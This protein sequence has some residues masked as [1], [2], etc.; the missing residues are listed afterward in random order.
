M[1]STKHCC[2]ICKK[3]FD[4][5]AGLYKHRRGKHPETLRVYANFTCCWDRFHCSATFRYV[6]EYI[7]HLQVKHP[8][9]NVLVEELR[10]DCESDFISWKE[11]IE[12]ETKS[13][14]VRN[15]GKRLLADGQA[16]LSFFCNRLGTF[17]S[18]KRSS[19]GDRK[20]SKKG[21]KFGSSKSTKSC[22]ASMYL[23]ISS[24]GQYEVKF[25]G[26]HLDH[27]LDLNHVDVLAALAAKSVDAVSDAAAKT[28][29]GVADGHGGA[30]ALLNAFDYV[31]VRRQ[32]QATVLEIGGG[33]TSLNY[34]GNPRQFIE[35]L[36]Q[37]KLSEID[38]DMLSNERFQKLIAHIVEIP[39]KATTTTTTAT[40]NSTLN[41]NSN[42]DEEIY[43]R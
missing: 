28:V 26:V 10:F 12:R 9:A 34:L 5:S 1:K 8:E 13:L 24:T 32:E 20:G 29:G 31:L 18:T 42:T 17:K 38:F 23:H 41:T 37:S 14:F 6:S 39:A 15:R 22:P 36:I 21:R 35:S 30:S 40:L 11:Q 19:K 33:G 16:K 3:S 4:T 7:D 43:M 25:I 27:E 2:D